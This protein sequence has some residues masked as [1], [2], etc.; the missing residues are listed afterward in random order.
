MKQ[1]KNKSKNETRNEMKLG[2]QEFNDR[3]RKS[4]KSMV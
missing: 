3:G 1:I 2:R 4:K